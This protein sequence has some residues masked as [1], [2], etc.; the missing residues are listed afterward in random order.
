[1]G[2][3]KGCLE[4]YPGLP[5]GVL[6]SKCKKL[7][8]GLTK[9]EVEALQVFNSLI[10]I[11]TSS[12]VCVPKCQPL[13]RHCGA[14][15]LFLP[16]RYCGRCSARGH[17][18]ERDE[19]PSTATHVGQH[20]QAFSSSA[21][22]HCL[23]QP[24]SQ[25]KQKLNPNLLKAA[26]VNTQKAHLKNLTKAQTIHVE[27]SL[28]LLDEKGKNHKC[29]LAPF[30]DT[31]DVNDPIDAALLTLS[32]KLKTSFLQSPYSCQFPDADFDFSFASCMLNSLSG[33]KSL[34][35][36]K[37]AISFK[38]NLESLYTHLVNSGYLSN[39]NKDACRLCLQI[40]VPISWD[41]DDHDLSS[42]AL[43]NNAKAQ[44]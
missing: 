8:K 7:V 24:K 32:E 22:E 26:T 35:I 4:V 44:T 20:A 36:N 31:F 6:C 17:G 23:N 27:L 34:S 1:M 18:E 9:V 19:D 11:L 39:M 38:A 29:Q 43:R 10:D 15:S 40:V 41:T 2:S 37:K 12:N 25:P 13:C 16:G 33:R 30:L 28:M 5:D 14:H 21:S 42:K 3:C